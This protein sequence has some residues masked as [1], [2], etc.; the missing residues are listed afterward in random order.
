MA[1]ITYEF[2][3]PPDPQKRDYDKDRAQEVAGYLARNSPRACTATEAWT[4]LHVA[5]RELDGAIREVWYHHDTG[6]LVLCPGGRVELLRA[7]NDAHYHG[8]PAVVPGALYR[9]YKG[10]LYRQLGMALE[11]PFPEFADPLS[12]WVIYRSEEKGTVWLRPL[13]DWLDN[14]KIQVDDTAQKIRMI[15]PRFSPV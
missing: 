6:R 7:P 3:P 8:L 15:T 10:G 12:C 13:L 11:V 5:V 2:R 4:R 9:H 14:V 1:D